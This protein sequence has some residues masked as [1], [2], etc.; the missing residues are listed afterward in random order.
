MTQSYI[1]LADYVVTKARQMGAG[2]SEAFLI[3]SKDLS[4]DVREGQVETMKLAED[5]GLGVRLFKDGRIGFAYTS[6]LNKSAVDEIIAQ[7]LKNSEKTTPDEFNVLP[8]K[9][10]GYPTLELFD[11]AIQKASVEEKIELAKNIENIAKGYDKRITN[12]ERS[13][14]FDA[15]YE[16]TLANSK[17]ISASYNGAYC[18]AY[19]DVV[20]E[21][22][23]ESQT[24]FGLQFILKYADLNPDAIGKEAAEKAVQKL[25][26][27]TIN[28]QK[29]YV[30]L[31]PYVATNFL[32][33]LSPALSAESVQKGKSLFAGKVGQKVAAEHIS[34]IDHGAMP[35]QMASAPFDG[36]GVP[37]S[38]TV[39]VKDGQLVGY[40]HNAYTARKDQVEPTGNG[41]RGSFKSTPEVGT[42]NFFIKPGTFSHD[43]I[44]AK[45]DK[46]LYITEVMGMHT[47]NPISGDFSLGASGIWIENGKM[48][49]PVRGVAIAGN[50]LELLE[51]VAAVGNDLRFF[52][53]KGSPTVC[54]SGITISGH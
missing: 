51:N 24:G 7:A 39:L 15:E 27:K 38:E 30:V 33:V 50:L 44:I 28:T 32:G 3:N 4:I 49:Y 41:T 35:G 16:V 36:E 23:G 40:L 20:A 26:A 46:G 53:G 18:G 13:A 29:A 47:A 11:Q 54:I 45:V 22:N 48:T 19:V 21:Q 2:E 12:T 31:D 52:G 14:Y 37:T 5:R 43:D 8:D 25:G 6:D 1:E 42:T 34:L 9:K 10:G 17:G